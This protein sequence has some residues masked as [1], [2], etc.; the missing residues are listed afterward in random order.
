MR[1]PTPSKINTG[2]QGVRGKRCRVLTSNFVIRLIKPAIMLTNRI[3]IPSRR[4]ANLCKNSDQVLLSTL[5]TLR[6]LIF[7]VRLRG[8]LIN[9][10]NVAWSLMER[11]DLYKSL[12]E[13]LSWYIYIAWTFVRSTRPA[14]IVERFQRTILH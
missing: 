8:N 12:L 3:V 11:L 5:Q 2:I 14:I 6:G 10:T 9:H 4:N 1:I 13:T 7:L